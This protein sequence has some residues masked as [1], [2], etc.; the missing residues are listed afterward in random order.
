MIPLSVL[1]HHGEPADP[2]LLEWIGHRID[3][4]VGVGP[5]ALATI[6]GLAIVAIPAALVAWY[7]LARR[8]RA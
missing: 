6:F 8:K 5:L 1:G 4:L 2:T 3:E 7:L